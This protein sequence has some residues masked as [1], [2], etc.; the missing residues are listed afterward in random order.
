M[1]PNPGKSVGNTVLREL[2]RECLLALRQ[3]IDSEVVGV[4]ELRCQ[5]GF[6]SQT[7]K[8]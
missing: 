7:N 2:G 8:D 4:D 3:N 1:P 6:A 5:H